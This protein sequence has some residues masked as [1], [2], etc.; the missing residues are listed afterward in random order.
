MLLMTL[1]GGSDA[2]GAEQWSEQFHQDLEK[3][4]ER[5]AK[6]RQTKQLE[7]LKDIKL[8]R[9]Q[10]AH[11]ASTLITPTERERGIYEEASSQPEV[12]SSF[13]VITQAVVF[14]W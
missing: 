7:K 1:I 6:Q 10:K 8:V 12:T 13:F 4:E 5:A 11:H 14:T 3:A 2:G 9:H